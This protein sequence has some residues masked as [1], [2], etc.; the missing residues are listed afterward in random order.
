LWGDEQGKFNI[1]LRCIYKLAPA[2]HD[3]I[4]EPLPAILIYVD[5]PTTRNRKDAD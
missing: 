4:H 2:G 3:I 1:L 5:S